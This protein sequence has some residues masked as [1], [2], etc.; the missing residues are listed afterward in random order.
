MRTVSY[1]IATKK[2]N[3]TK[4][5]KKNNQILTVVQTKDSIFLREIS[6]A[7]TPSEINRDFVTLEAT[8]IKLRSKSKKIRRKEDS[9]NVNMNKWKNN[10]TECLKSYLRVLEKLKM[11]DGKVK[12]K[13]NKLFNAIKKGKTFKK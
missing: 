9:N 1:L 5:Y 3:T 12:V 11:R 4:K 13:S 2:Q 8:F 10:L 6:L 7:M